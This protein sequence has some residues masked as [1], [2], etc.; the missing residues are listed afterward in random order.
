[1]YFINLKQD[2]LWG[3]LSVQYTLKSLNGLSVEPIP[4]LIQRDNGTTFPAMYGV[5]NKVC[6]AFFVE[7]YDA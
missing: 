1:M 6:I 7:V 2:N 4:A 3:V 5:V